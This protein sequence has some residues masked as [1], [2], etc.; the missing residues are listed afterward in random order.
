MGKVCGKDEVKPRRCNDKRFVNQRLQL[1][2]RLK[3][4]FLVQGERKNYD[5][6]H[7]CLHMYHDEVCAVSHQDQN[8]DQLYSTSPACLG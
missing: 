4:G 1:P 8:N 3:E 6:D 7:N 2:W 5:H